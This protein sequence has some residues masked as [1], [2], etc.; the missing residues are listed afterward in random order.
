MS[1]LSMNPLNSIKL[2][3]KKTDKRTSSYNPQNF[4]NM[5]ATNTMNSYSERNINGDGAEGG[6]KHDG[7]GLGIGI[8]SD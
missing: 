4:G 6:G 8:S 7:G 5:N 2:A 3:E 1:A